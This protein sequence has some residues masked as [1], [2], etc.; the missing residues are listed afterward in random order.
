MKLITEWDSNNNQFPGLYII[1]IIFFFIKK[2][3][4]KSAPTKYMM[5]QT[6]YFP[7]V[8]TSDM[9]PCK[10]I[11]AG[12]DY[13]CG[14]CRG[15]NVDFKCKMSIFEIPLPCLKYF[16][17]EILFSTPGDIK[18]E[19]RKILWLV[20]TDCVCHSRDLISQGGDF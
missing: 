4:K 8:E 9:R 3:Y 20:L 6:F 1:Y 2:W 14:Y 7:H 13:L 11:W 19:A 15:Q 10:D 16:W 17:V 12:C 5:R 18:Y